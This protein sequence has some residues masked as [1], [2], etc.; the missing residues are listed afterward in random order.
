MRGRHIHGA[1]DGANG[2]ASRF[3]A[4]YALGD[5]LTDTGNLSV[6]L[7]I[8]N[9]PVPD[10]NGQDVGVIMK[11]RKLVDGDLAISML[12][13]ELTSAQ[14][15][16]AS[17]L[18]GGNFAVAGAVANP[19]LAPFSPFTLPGTELQAQAGQLI[20]LNKLRRN[21]LVVI[22][23]G[24]NDIFASLFATVGSPPGSFEPEAALDVSAG[25]VRDAIK[26]LAAG[27]AQNFLVF[28]AANVGRTPIL[29][30]RVGAGA[31]PPQ[32]LDHAR[33]LT[34]SFNHLLF[35]KIG[36]LRRDS[37]FSANVWYVPTF[38]VAEFI[39]SPT[40]ARTT[41]ITSTTPCAPYFGLDTRC[42]ESAFW[43]FVHPSSAVHRVFGD[44]AKTLLRLPAYVRR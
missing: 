34:M 18:G 1:A 12:A 9:G 38:A 30:Q 32:T 33:A 22:F 2:K 16:T 31:L 3:N 37:G 4:I 7:R 20:S 39:A 25:N 11:D 43:D 42:S 19:A 8:E 28:E 41:G 29:S 6:I 44:V 26:R 17:L 10:R 24:S 40:G 23:I 14:D 13:E 15:V 5:S 36:A 21:D 35:Q 27:G